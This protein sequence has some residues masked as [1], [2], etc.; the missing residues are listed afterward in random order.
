[1]TQMQPLPEQLYEVKITAIEAYASLTAYNLEIKQAE[2]AL[3]AQNYETA[4]SHL[5]LA[6]NCVSNILRW[7]TVTGALSDFSKR[8]G[9][10]MVSSIMQGIGGEGPPY[11]L[12]AIIRLL[13]RWLKSSWAAKLS[14]IAGRVAAGLGAES[15]QIQAGFPGGVSIAVVFLAARSDSIAKQATRTRTGASTKKKGQKKQ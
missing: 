14:Q 12:D 4:F 13:E 5:L 9:E 2:E 3:A 15:Y 8:I 11:N 7:S 6:T 10:T 1:M